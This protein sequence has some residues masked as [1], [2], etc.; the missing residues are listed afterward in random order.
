MLDNCQKIF[1]IRIQS[2]SES[3]GETPPKEGM[4]EM[5][6]WNDAQRKEMIDVNDLKQ[7]KNNSDLKD[8]RLEMQCIIK[9][10]DGEGT[11]NF[12]K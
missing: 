12:K 6:D 3:W 1:K 11:D 7:I 5:K 10:M 4:K 8:L 2:K 9:G